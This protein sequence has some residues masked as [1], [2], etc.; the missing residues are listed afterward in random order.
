MDPDVLHHYCRRRCQL[1][2][3][4]SVGQ[5]SGSDRLVHFDPRERGAAKYKRLSRGG[6]Y[7]SAEPYANSECA[8]GQ[9]MEARAR[10]SYDVS[11]SVKMQSMG[12]ICPWGAYYNCWD[13]GARQSAR[14]SIRPTVVDQATGSRVKRPSL[15]QAHGKNSA[16]AATD[17]TGTVGAVV[18]S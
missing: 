15:E 14:E 1:K 7:A 4:A 13:I 18:S 10:R 3:R 8:I 6:R 11:R 9:R 2:P 12:N 5:I 16:D 17:H